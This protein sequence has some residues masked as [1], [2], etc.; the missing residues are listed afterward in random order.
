MLL[1]NFGPWIAVSMSATRPRPK[2]HP[3]GR[4]RG[5]RGR[6][7]SHHGTAGPFRIYA[8]VIHHDERTEPHTE[9]IREAI[10]EPVSAI[11]DAVRETLDRC[12]PELAGDVMSRGIVLAGG[13]ALLKGMDE[14]L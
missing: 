5:L 7:V 3:T 14:R 12:P 10:E 11:V 6:P 13:G 1:S 2:P 4:H 8:W 9:E